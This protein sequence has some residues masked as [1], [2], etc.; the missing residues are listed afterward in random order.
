MKRTIIAL[1]F[2]AAAGA[3]AAPAASDYPYQPVPLRQV[4][5]LDGFW[6]PRFE[7]N[8]LV[9]VWAD[10]KKSEETGRIANFAR[11]GKLEDGAFKG[12][13]FD[14]SDVYKIVEGA[15]YTLATHPD[16]QLDAYLDALIAK[17]A[18]A[19]E[20]DGYL[21][22]ARTLGFINGMTG[23]TRWSNMGA[24]HE[25]YNI[26]HLY[27][28]AAAHFAVTGKRTL[29]DVARKSADLIDRTFGPGKGQLK[30]TSGH[31]EIEIG[32]CKLYRATGERR[33]LDLA[34]FFIDMR[35][36]KDLRT[37]YGAYNQD[38]IPVLEQA[39]AV[40]HAVR[41]GYLYAGMADVAA[42]TGDKSYIDAIDK[43]WENV[44][45]KKLHLNGGIGAR[46][47]GEAFGENYELP[48]ESAYLETCAAIAN[49]LWNQRMF[50]LHGDAKYI[51]VLERV[52]YNGFLS[53][54]SISG[55]EFFYPNPLASRGGYKRSKWFGC[56][57]C[58][59]NIVRFIPQ[60]GQFTYA[61][62]DAAVY[63]NLFI[64]SSAKLATPA[65]EV[66]L[67][68]KTGYPWT[69]DVRIEVAPA[70]DGAVFPLKVRVPGWAFGKPV[71]S[72]LYTQTN[73]GAL[74]DVAV[75][76]NGAPVTLAL[77]QGY[78]TLDRAWRKGD[79]VTL[80]FAMPVRRI[81]AHPAVKD[82]VGRL[83]V[84]RGPLVYCAESADNDGH[85]LN[86]AL[87]AAA[88]FTETPA[89]L[90]GHPV[91][92]LKAQAL[93]VTAD[94]R[95]NRSSRPAVATLIPYFAWCHR[96]AGEMQV[97]FPASAEAATPLSD[98]TL[99][100]SHCFENDALA[101]ACDGE[102][103]KRSGDHDVKRFTWWPNKGSAEWL[104]VGFT[105][106]ETLKGCAVYWFDDTGKGAC[107]V[108]A[109]WKVQYPDAAGNW[110]DV[111]AT[112]PVAKDR[113]CEARFAAP[114]TVRS[115]RLSVQLQPDVSGGVLEW[116]F[117]TE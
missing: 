29:L 117:L 40:G 109:S 82:D 54:I 5:I 95:G 16:P 7:T 68:Q 8:R 24:S 114:V 27:E 39:E 42:L 71:P 50:L 59:V 78:V 41:A 25:L 62:R 81:Q 105:A 85:A 73:P 69:G 108:P 48:N 53:G 66:T 46:H 101:A 89:M 72:D 107:R 47:Q 84:E 110:Q 49:A 63:V 34:K 32:L 80:A 92:A 51:D 116:K 9:T 96:G 22:T 99:S 93:S 31:E 103:P 20:P 6:L 38:H 28:A 67:T 90:L 60:F 65:G 57:C 115:L 36:R 30:G 58:P 79:A 56:S 76:V 33:Y 100:A 91:V 102:L 13:P 23:K 35:G 111:P 44:V 106:P 112:Y 18:A 37:L 3:G 86:L 55:D 26:G 97:W 43:L 70:Q 12:I 2:S 14:D 87:P 61:Q 104:Q 1:A 94:L 21:Y 98:L 15:A 11:A 77:D 75:A 74:R 10:F 4:A 17:M 88:T 113:L 64:A 45:S 83:A 19:Q 52:I